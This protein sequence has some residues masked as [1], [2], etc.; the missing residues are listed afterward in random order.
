MKVTRHY[1]NVSL[2]AEGATHLEV[3][4]ELAALEEVFS[5]AKCGKCGSE[6]IRFRV[7]SVQDGKKEYEYPEMLCG[8]CWAKLSFG[9]SEGGKLFPVRYER[10]G[11]EYKKDADGNYI[12]RGT[13]GWVKY[14]KETGKEE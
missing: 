4:K 10:E 14:N 5:E 7:R 1:T 13:R 9:Q 8:G 11:G 6:D 3:V 2:T 12:P